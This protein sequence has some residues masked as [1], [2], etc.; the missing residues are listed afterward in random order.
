M[1]RD[2][3]VIAAKILDASLAI[4][5]FHVPGFVERFGTSVDG[6]VVGGVRVFDVV[7]KVGGKFGGFGPADAAHLQHGIT[8]FDSGVHDEA[9][10]AHTADQLL[11]VEGGF[12][13]I[14]KRGWIA[15]DQIRGDIA[16]SWRDR[17]R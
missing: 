9:V 8:D 3:P 1:R 11:S 16:K 15:K 4:A 6:A 13:E 12:K 14:E 10:G 5:V 7:M 17:V 2:V